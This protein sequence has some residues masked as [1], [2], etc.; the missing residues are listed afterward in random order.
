M[1]V[2]LV[3]VRLH[4]AAG[5]LDGCSSHYCKFLLQPPPPPPPPQ[6]FLFFDRVSTFDAG[7][8][9]HY[10]GS[11]TEAGASMALGGL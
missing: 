7:G 8:H 2:T 4:A 6:S 1:L 3:A 11:T 5:M 9:A 10:A